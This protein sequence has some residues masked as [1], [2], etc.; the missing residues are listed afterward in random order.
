M[1]R[2]TELK[3]GWQPLNAPTRPQAS[4]NAEWL[5]RTLSAWLAALLLATFV[6]GAAIGFLT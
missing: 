3:N 1:K 2:G 6:V 5:P 4:S